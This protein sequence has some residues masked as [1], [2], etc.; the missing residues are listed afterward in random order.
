MNQL[1]DT[2]SARGSDTDLDTPAP[3]P[4]PAGSGAAVLLPLNVD[5]GAPEIHTSTPLEKEE[6]EEEEV[7]CHSSAC[8]SHEGGE[9]NCKCLWRRRAQQLGGSGGCCKLKLLNLAWINNIDD[10]AIL[11]LSCCFE[12]CVVLNYYGDPLQSGRPMVGSGADDN[13][14]WDVESL[15]EGEW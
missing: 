9:G 7:E 1:G 2:N 4:A 10:A 11:A 6:E 5:A 12:P 15:V 13:R 8:S 3:A 14:G